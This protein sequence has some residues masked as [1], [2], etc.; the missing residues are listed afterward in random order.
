MTAAAGI[1]SRA[2]PRLSRSLFSFGGVSQV[3]TLRRCSI[4]RN[5]GA[6]AS[7]L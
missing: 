3:L 6:S 2:A 5:H 7:A 4:I 1:P